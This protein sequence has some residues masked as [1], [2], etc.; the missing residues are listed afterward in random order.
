MFFAHPF[1]VDDVPYSRGMYILKPYNL[2][3]FPC[4]SYLRCHI[5][6]GIVPNVMSSLRTPTIASIRSFLFCCLLFG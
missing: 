2:Q 4:G 1:N 6:H 5:P 3:V